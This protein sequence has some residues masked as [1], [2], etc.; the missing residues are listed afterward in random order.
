M[1][2][3]Q[4]KITGSGK[5]IR[6]PIKPLKLSVSTDGVTIRL[7]TDAQSAGYSV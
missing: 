6:V 4:T 1:I 3:S 7:A 5:V 2:R